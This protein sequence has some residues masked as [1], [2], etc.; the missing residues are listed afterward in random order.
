VIVTRTLKKAMRGDAQARRD[1]W[2][3]IEGKVPEA[4]PDPEPDSPNEDAIDLKQP[5]RFPDD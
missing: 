1:I 3:R 5:E 4:K 2:E